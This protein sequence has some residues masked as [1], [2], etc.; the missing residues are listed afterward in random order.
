MTFLDS[1]GDGLLRTDTVGRVRVPRELSSNC[2]WSVALRCFFPRPFRVISS[3]LLLICEL[4]ASDA[5]VPEPPRLC[6]YRFS[7]HQVRSN[8]RMGRSFLKKSLDSGNDALAKFGV[9]VLLS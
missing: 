8:F 2:S 4:H 7:A 6:R 3:G 1:A 9:S 5:V